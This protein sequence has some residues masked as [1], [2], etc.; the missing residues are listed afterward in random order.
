MY[1]FNYLA[2]SFRFCLQKSSVYHCNKCRLQF[3]FTKEKVDHKVNHHKTFRKPAPLEGLQAGTKVS[4][5]TQ[6]YLNT[7][8]CVAFFLLW[9][10]CPNISTITVMSYW[11]VLFMF[12]LF[13]WLD[14]SFTCPPCLSVQVTIRAYAGHKRFTGLTGP[15]SCKDTLVPQSS[16]PAK[17]QI[18]KMY[19]YLTK[20][21]EYR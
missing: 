2:D 14:N 3:L 5:N 15:K 13:L 10:H 1:L 7:K 6:I 8:V 20:F 18:T 9:E 16:G 21:Q 19:G 17:K 12:N 11:V 4:I